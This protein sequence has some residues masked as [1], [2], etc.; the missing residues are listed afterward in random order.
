MSDDQLRISDAEREQAAAELAD[1]YAQ[2]RLTAEEHGERLDRIW[3]ART[4]GELAP[5]FRD[6]PGRHGPRPTPTPGGDRE[7]L[8]P[9]R[10]GAPPT[11][12]L[13]VLAVLLVIT[14]MTHLPIILIGLLVWWLVISKARRHHWSR[15]W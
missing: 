3:T 7:R 8:T 6:L 4:R 11:P 10:G 12:L 15:R 1:H 13:V 5:I 2:G 9:R 14:V